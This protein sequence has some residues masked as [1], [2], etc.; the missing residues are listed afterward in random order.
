MLSD[1][2]CVKNY[3]EYEDDFG[4][5]DVCDYGFIHGRLQW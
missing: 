3:E 4:H 2:Y 5:V 1:T